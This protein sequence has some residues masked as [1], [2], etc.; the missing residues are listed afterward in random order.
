MIWVMITAP[1]AIGCYSSDGYYSGSCPKRV[2]MVGLLHLSSDCARAVTAIMHVTTSPS[3]KSTS[4]G[5]VASGVSC[6][7][8]DCPKQAASRALSSSLRQHHRCNQPRAE[9]VLGRVEAEFKVVA[10]KQPAQSGVAAPDR[11]SR[12]AS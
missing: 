11:E 3:K 8:A 6:V 5:L 9:A 12:G 7:R 2:P 1:T 4:F 10:A